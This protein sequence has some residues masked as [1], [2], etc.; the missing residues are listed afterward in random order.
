MYFFHKYFTLNNSKRIICFFLIF[1]YTWIGKTVLFFFA[2]RESMVDIF[3]HVYTMKFAKTLIPAFLLIAFGALLGSW[4]MQYYGSSNT[5][6]QE[7]SPFRTE[8][9]ELVEK[10]I[11]K[12]YYK[13][14]EKS[15]TE[16]E[17]GVIT[18]LVWALWDKH[19]TYFSPDEAK[20]FSEVLRGDFEGIW[21]VID[22][23]SRGIIIR[24]I[25]KDSPAKNAWLQEGDILLQVDDTTMAWLRADEAVKIIRWPKGSKVKISYSRWDD[26]VAKTVEVIRD[27]INIPS[28]YEYMLTGSLSDVGYIEV[29]FF[30]EKTT[31]EFLQS[32]ERLTASW[33]KWLILDF[34]NNGWWY[35]DTA[36]D[37]L[38]F[39]LPDDS[40]AVITRENNP[41]KTVE[42]HT[43][44]TKF[45][46]STIPIVMI[47]NG[48]SASATEIV[49]WAFQDHER[50]I[51]LW[52][53]TYGKWSVQEPFS[54]TDGSIIKLTVGRW[55]S[56][57]E[58]NIDK[59]GI[60]PDILVPLFERDFANRYDRQLEAA[61]KLIDQVLSTNESRATIIKNFNTQEF[62]E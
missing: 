12:N 58:Q 62:T 13:F 6:S 47:V 7:D 30:W 24:K 17:N 50:A 52:E 8:K 57:K 9:T 18:S 25:I 54:L 56:P 20:E 37:M 53:K 49:A 48:L 19:S 14:S 38:S 39:L 11:K 45:T 59:N 1:S 4:A 29:S 36:V 16:I 60:T 42:I 44:Q 27:T 10:I 28:T 43:K 2:Q 23:H 46:N 32:F 55:Y 3:K 40:L 26:L 51:V 61:K 31:E 5:S 34:R 21:A 41:K 33:A 22:T 15:K 35:L